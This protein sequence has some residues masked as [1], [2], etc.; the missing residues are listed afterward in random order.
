MKRG[1]VMEVGMSHGN[2]KHTLP[3]LRNEFSGGD[4]GIL[5]VSERDLKHLEAG[6]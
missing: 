6:G 1:D 3:K 5:A 4:K 2:P